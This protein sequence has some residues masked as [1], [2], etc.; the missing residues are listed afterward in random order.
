V[1]TT[2]I[3]LAA[4][5][6][7]R[8]GEAT[9]GRSKAM[10]PVLGKPMIAHVMHEMSVSGIQ[11]FIVVAAPSDAELKSYF[12][13][14]TDVQVVEQGAPRGSGDALRVCKGY[15][16]GSFVVSACDSIVPSHDIKALCERHE[17][18]QADASIGV[19]QV[20]ADTPLEARSVVR[21][22]QGRVVE[23]IEKPGPT[24]RISNITALPLYVCT[25]DV[26]VWLP[27]LVPSERGEYE[28]P[29]VFAKLAREL[30][31][32]LPSSERNIPPKAP[33]II[34]FEVS[35]RHDL[36]SASDLLALN[37]LFMSGMSPSVQIDSAAL[38]D[39]GVTIVPPVCVG[40][41]CTVEQGASLGPFVYLEADIFV[42]SGA[43]I[44]RTVAL[45]GSYIQGP[46]D[47]QIVCSNQ[48]KTD[49]IATERKIV[50]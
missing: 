41:R 27:A 4:G 33:K 48:Q 14:R 13:A 10:V 35:H 6:G 37:H 34:G 21:I 15:V 16:S 45:R 42:A 30:P 3:I 1:I 31:A 17:S 36:T 26:F 39:P 22:E 47:S 23:L 5:R 38:V 25:E 50:T 11:R 2:A 29:A 24:E 12:A 32:R 19:M 7:T 20:S 49:D 40:P 18:E 28:L 9:R 44:K 46:V 8:L 43:S